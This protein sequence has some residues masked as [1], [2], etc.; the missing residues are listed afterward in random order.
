MYGLE[1]VFAAS[2][3]H[4]NVQLA[5]CVLKP[6]DVYPIGAISLTPLPPHHMSVT[7][8]MMRGRRR[9]GG[10]THTTKNSLYTWKAP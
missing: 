2:G 5:G 3:V 9:G 6:S 10:V 1:F 8:E 7:G 4:G